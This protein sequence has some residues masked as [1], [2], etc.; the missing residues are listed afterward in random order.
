MKGIDKMGL[1]LY[2][3]ICLFAILNIYSVE[4]AAGKR[5]AIWFGISLLMGFIIFVSRPKL[6][7][8]FSAIGYFIGILLLIGLFP[9]GTKVLGQRNWYKLGPLSLQPV[10]FAK[11][12]TALMLSNF[13]SSP[14]YKRYSQKSIWKAL[15]I[16]AVPAVVVLA[17]PDVGSMLVFSSFLIPM[18]REGLS[19]FIFGLI[20]LVAAVFLFSI[21][22]NPLYVIAA[23]ALLYA[24]A[25]FKNKNNISWNIFSIS[26]WAGSFVLLSALAWFS[27]IVLKKLPTHQRERIEV[28]YLGEKNFRE[29]SG[30]NLL[31]SKT[32]IGSGGLLGKGFK[33][34]SI[35]RGEFVPEQSTDY[36]FCAVGE[37]WGFLGSAGLVLI[38]ALYIARIYYLAE[39]QKS[40]FNRVFGY[41]F[42]SILFFHF[43]INLFMVL[44]LFPTV[45]IP[46]PYF[47]YGGS[48]LLAFSTMTFIF[49]K[50]N[51]TDKRALV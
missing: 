22:V 42:A 23:L 35:T 16:I 50:L 49:F 48:S 7:E 41:C 13:L 26:I 15:L 30:Y 11:I 39:N 25:Y 46:L 34:G 17:I 10:E 38:Y 47:S 9:F 21:G 43:G 2:I 44:G 31:F 19:G 4:E 12:G 33:N 40:K 14:D 32:A 37:E 20:G 36:I 18:Y 6:F 5:Q 8:N 3:I 27:P 24:Y 51:Y 45:G 1:G 29:T 28:L